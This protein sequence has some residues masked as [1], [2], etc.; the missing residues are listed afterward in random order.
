MHV[1]IIIIIIKSMSKRE[2]DF[3]FAGSFPKISEVVELRQT[4]NQFRY[5]EWVAET[6]LL[7]LSQLYLACALAGVG[8]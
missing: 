7:E 5:A 3:L 1:I 2:K 6:V 8:N 4:G